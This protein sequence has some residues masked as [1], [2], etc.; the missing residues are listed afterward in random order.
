MLYRNQLQSVFPLCYWIVSIFL[1]TNSLWKYCFSVYIWHPY[2]CSWIHS[3]CCLLNKSSYPQGKVHALSIFSYIPYANFCT[4]KSGAYAFLIGGSSIVF[5]LLRSLW[6][7]FYSVMREYNY[8]VLGY[9]IFRSII[10]FGLCYRFGPVTNPK[11]THLLQWALQ[12][13]SYYL[14][15]WEERYSF[16]FVTSPLDCI[17]F[18]PAANIKKQLWDS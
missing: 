2:W 13:H 7:N 17:L 3:Y 8:Y 4:Q 1:C 12:V 6:D 16:T 10:S 5:Y 9:L 15:V 11:T 14:Y 18:S